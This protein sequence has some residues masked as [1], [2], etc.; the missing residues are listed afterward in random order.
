MTPPASGPTRSRSR[1]FYVRVAVLLTILFVVVLWAVHD[2]RSRRARN[3]WDHTLDVAIT[4]VRVEQVDGA[5]IDALRAQ[6]PLLEDRLAAELHR[7]RPDAPRP[8]RFHLAGPV[9]G[10]SPPAAPPSDS[11]VDLAGYSLDL[12]RYLGHIDERS[13]LESRLYDSRIY[14][15]LR[16]PRLA[17]RTLVEGRSEQGG[18]VG[19]VEMEL[20]DGAEAAHLPLIVVAHELLHT[21]GAADKYDAAGRTRIPLGLA[22]PERVPLY[23]QRFAEIMAR[24]R[25]VSAT[26]EKVPD[27][28][29][30]IA[31]GSATAREIGWLR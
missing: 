4:L 28:F 25:P 21:L 10:L 7:Y 24:N 1:F 26:A 16:K 5:A 15:A 11:P 17:L 12:W 20:D 8:F 18:R 30:E 13:G 9:D 19:V 6:L 29:A 27:S 23:P 3:D 2:V 22:E 14:L 31:V